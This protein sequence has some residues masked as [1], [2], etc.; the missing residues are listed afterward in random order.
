MLP[1][2][3]YHWAPTERRA[4]IQR[5]GL[6]PGRLSVCG[7]WRPPYVCFA[8]DPRWAWALSPRFN[9]DVESWD[10]WSVHTSALSGYEEVG[11]RGGNVHEFRVYERVYKRDVWFVGTRTR[12]GESG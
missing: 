9:K 1:V 12:A 3:L 6:V 8:D 11:S 2:V 5:L 10:L 7:R 4:S